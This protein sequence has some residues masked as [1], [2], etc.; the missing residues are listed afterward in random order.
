MKRILFISSTRI[1]DAVLS[2][3]LLAHLAQAHP[4]AQIT[5]ACGPLAAPLFRAAPRVERVI[6]M[7]KRRMGGHWIDLWL[8][9]LPHRWDL[10]VDLRGSAT[11][12]F[13]NA[14]R[15]RVKARLEIERDPPVHK[16]IEAARVLKLD[17]PPA[18]VLWLDAAAEA[19]AENRLPEGAPI[20]ALAPAASAPFKEWPAER[21][22][23]L[24]ARLTGAGGAL[25]GARVAVF[26]GPGDEETARASVEGLDAARVIDLSGRLGI[27]ESAAC[28]ARARL[29]IG[30]DSGLMHLAAA[31]G[32]PALGLFGPTDERLYGPWGGRAVR[33]GEALPERKRHSLNAHEGSLLGALSVDVVEQAARELLD[34]PA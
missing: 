1:G 13:L 11:G 14:R 2:S 16:V 5:I 6:V 32:T 17:P 26:G 8:K 34:A 9:A 22:A 12:L 27:L 29:F 20:L 25:A 23:A 4:E 15:R 18:P 28:L 3:G 7:T 19:E 33:A 10:V 24:A 31:A 30:N 21:F